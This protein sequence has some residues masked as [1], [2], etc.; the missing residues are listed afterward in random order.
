MRTHVLVAAAALVTVGLTAGCERTTP[1]TVAMTTEPGPP[2]TSTTR[3]P[4]TTSIPG[5]PSI[6]LPDIP[7]PGFP[8]NTDVPEVPA[9][10][11]AL[12][13]KCEEFNKLD[14]ATRL[15][16]IRAILAQENN[17]LG[18]NGESVGQMLVEAACQ[19]LPSATVSEVLMGTPPR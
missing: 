5:L 12:T 16:V 3:E 13:M 9:P 14:E 8:R 11:D 7:F 2:I 6:P 18:P 10:P 1:G 17:P 19:F 4:R 15:A